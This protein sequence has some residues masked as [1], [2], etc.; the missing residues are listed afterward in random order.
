METK[1]G[2][3]EKLKPVMLAVEMQMRNPFQRWTW[4]WEKRIRRN[5]SDVQ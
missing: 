4:F 3:F 1:G 5:F 2:E